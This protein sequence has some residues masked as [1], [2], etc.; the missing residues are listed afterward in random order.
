[1]ASIKRKSKVSRI[2]VDL[3]KQIKD[4][5]E[6]NNMKITEASRELAK[7]FGNIKFNK[8]KALKRE[9]VF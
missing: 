3:E 6:K 7:I 8:R 2:S 5:A 9:I 1:M 4:F